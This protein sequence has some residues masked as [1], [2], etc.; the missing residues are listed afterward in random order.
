MRVNII[1]FFMKYR[2]LLLELMKKLPLCAGPSNLKP[3]ILKGLPLLVRLW[4]FLILLLIIRWI[5]PQINFIKVNIDS[6]ISHEGC[7]CGDIIRDCK[8]NIFFSF[9]S[10]L[11]VLC[12]LWSSRLIILLLIFVHIIVY[13][14]FGLKLMFWSLYL[15]WSLIK[16]VMRVIS[17]YSI[18]SRICCPTW[19]NIISHIPR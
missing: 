15:F 3:L 17:I 6:F 4:I 13:A 19:T 16:E 12:L 7:G 18:L 9:A 11:D 2:E 5:K 10:P 8:G 1:I 14:T